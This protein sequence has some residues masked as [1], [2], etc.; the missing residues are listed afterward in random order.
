MSK[1]VGLP[2]INSQKV[3]N[4]ST[5][6]TAEESVW[7]LDEI[8]AKFG[9]SEK[10]ANQILSQMCKRLLKLFVEDNYIESKN[11]FMFGI[12]YK[13]FKFKLENDLKEKIKSNFKK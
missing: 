1:F 5:D 8:V 11:F 2:G 10:Q 9:V 3:N 7:I 12:I 13:Q 6:L 4:Y